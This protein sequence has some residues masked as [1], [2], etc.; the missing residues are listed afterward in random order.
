M[1]H[2]LKE[3]SQLHNIKVQD[4]VTSADVE[5]ASNPEDLVKIINE[6]GCTNN[7]AFSADKTAFCRKKMPS[8]TF[9]AR[10]KSVRVLKASKDRLMLLLQTNTPHDFKQKPVFIF[11]SEIVKTVKNYFKCTLSML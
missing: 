3:I 7:T 6:G 11:H 8:R 9:T 4:Q 2:G 10:E 5:T 1:D